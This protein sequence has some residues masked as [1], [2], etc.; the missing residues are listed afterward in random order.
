MKVTLNG[1]MQWNMQ[2]KGSVKPNQDLI[3]EEISKS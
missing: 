1:Q 3:Q 2:Y